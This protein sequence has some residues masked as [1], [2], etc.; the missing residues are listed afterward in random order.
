MSWTNG[1]IAQSYARAMGVWPVLA[2]I[3]ALSREWNATLVVSWANPYSDSYP[4]LQQ[5]AAAEGLPFADWVP[6]MKAVQA[7]MPDLN[8]ANPHSGGHWRPWTNGVIA[9]SYARAM[10]VWP[11]PAGPPPTPSAR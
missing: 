5:K 1:V 3:V 11:P 2:E 7:R 6:A 4:W 10:G 8:Y 9:Q